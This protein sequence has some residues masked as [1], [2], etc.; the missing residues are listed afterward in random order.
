MGQLWDLDIQFT[1][2][3][4][5]FSDRINEAIAPNLPFINHAWEFEQTILPQYFGTRHRP[6]SMSENTMALLIE[7]F[8]MP[9][10][11]TA[12]AACL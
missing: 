5:K 11:P 9:K 10:K 8:F 4:D 12:V 7:H 1:Q 2:P 6:F 3:S